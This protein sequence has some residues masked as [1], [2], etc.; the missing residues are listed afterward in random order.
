MYVYDDF[1]HFAEWQKSVVHGGTM[2]AAG[3]GALLAAPVVRLFDKKQA[4]YMFLSLSC[5]GNVVLLVLFATGRIAPD[6]AWGAI[7]AAM[8]IFMAFHVCFHLGATAANTI[9]NSMMADVSEVNLF[10][11]GLLKDGSYSA[12]LSFVL[13]TSIT[14]GLV[15]CGLA[16]DAM[17]FDSNA[18]HQTPEVAKRLF[19]AG[20]GGG[21]VITALAMV[22]LIFYPVNREY[23]AQIKRRLAAGREPPGGLPV[24]PAEGPGGDSAGS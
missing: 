16:L 17:G 11:T 14:V 7:P 9:A 20:F 4:I 21:A 3:I 10:R 23:M 13:K 5:F 24:I 8:L 22:G 2:V 6:L 19:L 1:M 15:L 18:Q 12:M